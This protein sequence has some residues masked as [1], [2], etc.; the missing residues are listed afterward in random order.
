MIHPPLLVTC[1]GAYADSGL[2]TGGTVLVHDG[3]STIIDRSDATGLWM[4]GDL[5]YRFSRSRHAVTGMDKSGVR[6]MLH[7]PE[8]RDVHD[9]A[10]VDNQLLCICSGTNEVLWFDLQG[11]LLRRWVA[12]GEGDAWHLNCV[13][14]TDGR[15]YLMAFGEFSTHRAWT[16]GCKHQGFIFDLETGERV[17][18]G[19]SGPHNPRLIDGKW[20]ICDSHTESLVLYESGKE[21]ARV[22]LS[23]FT[24]GLA[25]DDRYL[26]VGESADRKSADPGAHSTIAILDRTSMTV[27]DRLSIP[28][29][30][31]YEILVLSSQWAEPISMAPERYTLDPTNERIG[32]LEAQVKRG[33][34]DTRVLRGQ[35]ERWNRSLIGRISRGLKRVTR[36]R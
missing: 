7:L 2:G 16:D 33:E 28:F 23:G 17:V 31:V 4:S 9:I 36:R 10:V 13:W 18:T 29:P 12:P 35:I 30:E 27:V 11:R 15:I 25:F 19:L 32:I 21:S 20:Y 8:A 3:K 22:K 34:E 6:L 26:Y 5:I 24:R 1:P 14:P